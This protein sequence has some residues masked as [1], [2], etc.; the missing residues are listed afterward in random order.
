MLV[1]GSFSAV[2]LNLQISFFFIVFS[3]K[4]HFEENMRNARNKSL[5][6]IK[7]QG[8]EKDEEKQGMSLTAFNKVDFTH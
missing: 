6:T 3:V 2:S 7:R 5:L 4:Q 8:F 1:S